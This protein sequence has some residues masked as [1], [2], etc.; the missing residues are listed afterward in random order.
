M[1]YSSIDKIK[2][3]LRKIRDKLTQKTPAERPEPALWVGGAPPR[4]TPLPVATFADLE[5]YCL[6]IGYPHS[7][8]SIIGAILNAHSEAVVS[9]ELRD[10]RYLW[11]GAAREELFTA[12]LEHDRQWTRDGSIGGG[13]YSYAVPG[14]WQGRYSRLRVLGDKGGGKLSEVLLKKDPRLL[15]K[16]RSW[17]GLPL[18][19][20]HITRNP[21]DT[22]GAMYA[23]LGRPLDNPQRDLDECIR[24][25]FEL[26]GVIHESIKDMPK[27]EL[28]ILRHEDFI[29]HPR[30]CIGRLCRFLGLGCD[31]GYLED[32]ASI[33][34]AGANKRRMEINWPRRAVAEVAA[35]IGRYPRELGHYNFV[36]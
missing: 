22:I 23:P 16:M 13:G 5:R 20:V 18:R 24:R 6:F 26:A 8:H 12:I 17:I 10:F 29:A 31:D 3:R 15:E 14:Q 36:G 32:C 4:H 9:N 34:Y 7:G 25:Y 11:E 1:L 28:L 27:D 2:P 33:V 21:Y 30:D 19:L 35:H